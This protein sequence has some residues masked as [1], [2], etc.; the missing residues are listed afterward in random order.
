[1]ARALEH[2]AAKK[3]IPTSY[4]RLTPDVCAVRL[5]RANAKRMR[6][7]G[8]NDDDG[9]PDKRSNFRTYYPSHG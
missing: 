9:P 2:I 8:D 7:K 5:K 3:L 6:D 1:M 4:E